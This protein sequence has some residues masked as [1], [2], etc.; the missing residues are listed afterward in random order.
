MA[1]NIRTWQDFFDKREVR[2]AA[3]VQPGRYAV[4]KPWKNKYWRLSR[5]EKTILRQVS[6]PADSGNL[7]EMELVFADESGGEKSR[8][9]VSGFN[10]ADLPKLAVEQYDQGLSMPMGIGIPPFFQ[11]YD[12]LQNNPP[13]KSPFFS[14]LLDGAGHWLNHHT[15][16]LDGSVLHLDILDQGLLHLY[17]LSYER[18][19]LIGHFLISTTG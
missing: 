18:H 5:F 14:V 7:L 15:I 13:D 17:L 10:L 1:E 4:R 16:A 19:T 9:I 11:S 3:F 6:G 12:N 8:F 2:F